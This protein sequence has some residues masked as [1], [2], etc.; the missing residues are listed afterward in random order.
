MTPA[1]LKFARRC[2]DNASQANFD[3]RFVE[4]IAKQLDDLGKLSQF[5]IAALETE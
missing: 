1:G 5:I 3:S 4:I 2:H